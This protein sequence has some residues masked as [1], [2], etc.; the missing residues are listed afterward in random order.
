METIPGRLQS[1][2]LAKTMNC[3]GRLGA[4]HCRLFRFYACPDK[5]GRALL[6]S[7]SLSHFSAAMSVLKQRAGKKSVAGQQRLRSFGLIFLLLVGLAL[8]LLWRS[9]YNQ[10]LIKTVDDPAAEI[11]ALNEAFETYRALHGEY[12]P[13]LSADEAVVRKHLQMRFPSMAADETLAT[14]VDAAEALVFWLGGFSTNRAYPITG[15]GGPL[16]VDGPRRYGIYEFDPKRLVPTSYG[17][18]MYVPPGVGR[19]EPYVYFRAA[20]RRKLVYPAKEPRIE[21]YRKSETEYVNRTSF[22]VLSAGEDDRWGDL[23]APYF[24]AGPFAGG[25]ADN[26]TNF[27]TVPLG[28]VKP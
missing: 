24:P 19:T 14:Q 22:Q 18:E 4:L 7:M 9:D 28:E 23:P 15:L 20:G 13:N 11:V 27:S 26:R 2:P 5:H 1:L 10:P 21:A 6:S 17:K 3:S 16:N 12:P 8:A 25:H